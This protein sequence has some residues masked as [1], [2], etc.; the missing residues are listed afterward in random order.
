MTN[1]G[2]RDKQKKKAG[3]GKLSGSRV[4]N[5]RIMRILHKLM[6][7]KRKRGTFFYCERGDAGYKVGGG[8]WLEG[9]LKEREIR[10]CTTR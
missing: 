4:K 10:R 7:Y 9:V 6:H 5:C 3:G 1:T 2:Q 8:G